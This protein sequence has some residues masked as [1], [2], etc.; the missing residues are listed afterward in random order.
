MLW[1]CRS[2]AA[3]KW[4]GAE[5][6]ADRAWRCRKSEAC[7]KRDSGQNPDQVCAAVQLGQGLHPA[8][9]R[10]GVLLKVG[11]RGMLAWGGEAVSNLLCP[12]CVA[13]IWVCDIGGIVPVN[14]VIVTTHAHTALPK[15][16]LKNQI[17]LF[18]LMVWFLQ[19]CEVQKAA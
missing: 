3:V 18:Y 1:V 13:P 19:K 11:L 7:A 10:H 4:Q 12:G 16:I 6:E 2:K 5:E 9:G 17:R 8:V 15:I 14:A